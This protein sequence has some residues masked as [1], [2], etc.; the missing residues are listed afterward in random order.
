MIFAGNEQYDTGAG[1]PVPAGATTVRLWLPE[2]KATL[3]ARGS[4]SSI[5]RTKDRSAAM[6][7][8]AKEE[9]DIPVDEKVQREV[10]LRVAAAPAVEAEEA[11]P[12]A[13]DAAKKK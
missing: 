9:V 8:L 3:L 1:L 5:V 10:V 2:G 7:P 13:E 11:K 6:A 4:A 12:A